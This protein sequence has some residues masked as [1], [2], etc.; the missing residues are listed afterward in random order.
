MLINQPHEYYDLA[1]MN[2]DAQLCKKNETPDFTHL[3][4]QYKKDFENEMKK[5]KPLIK[6]N[7]EMII[8]V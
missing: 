8:W 1:E 7:T 2:L 5:M 3:F 4:V 6:K